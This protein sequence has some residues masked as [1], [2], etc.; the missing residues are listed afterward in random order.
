[1]FSWI[2]VVPP[3]IIALGDATNASTG[4]RRPTSGS[5]TFPRV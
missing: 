4:S 2:S 1:M 5:S 3:A